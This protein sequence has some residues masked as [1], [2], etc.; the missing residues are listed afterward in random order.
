MYGLNAM[1]KPGTGARPLQVLESFHMTLLLGDLPRS[2][3]LILPAL[4]LLILARSIRQE[5][6]DRFATVVGGS[7]IEFRPAGL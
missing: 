5:I 7:Y 3:T 4:D 2:T 1:P 6:H